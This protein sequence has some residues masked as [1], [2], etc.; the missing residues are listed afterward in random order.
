MAC[1]ALGER[2]ADPATDAARS[3][4]DDGHLA[5]DLHRNLPSRVRSGPCSPRSTARQFTPLKNPPFTAGGEA[6][7]AGASA[8]LLPTSWVTRRGGPPSH[9]GRIEPEA[10]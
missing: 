3:P 6:V 5:S 8:V 4:R 9:F 10:R 7:D 1:A 2:P